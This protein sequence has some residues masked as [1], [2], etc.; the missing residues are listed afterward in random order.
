M[1]F[2]LATGQPTSCGVG[3]KAFDVHRSKVNL[4]AVVI[5]KG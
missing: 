5:I 1:T 2:V 4:I 3:A